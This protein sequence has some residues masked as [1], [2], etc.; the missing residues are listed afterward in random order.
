[1]S[2]SAIDRTCPECGKGNI[3][4]KGRTAL[5]YPRRIADP[6]DIRRGK[7]VI[8]TKFRCRDCGHEFSEIEEHQ[9]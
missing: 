3:E 8:E 1:M 7:K 6:A 4:Y 5:F 9:F 2:D